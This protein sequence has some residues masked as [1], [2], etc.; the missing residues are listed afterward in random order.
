MANK[1]FSPPTSLL[2]KKKSANEV[3]DHT[4]VEEELASAAAAK[5]KPNKLLEV[6][7]EGEIDVNGSQGSSKECSQS[8]C[9]TK[10]GSRFKSIL[11]KEGKEL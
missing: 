9:H 3:C 11:E 10:A 2:A 8:P 6:E 5:P 1:E 7:V 4:T